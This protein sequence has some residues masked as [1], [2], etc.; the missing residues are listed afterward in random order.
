MFGFVQ[1][2][3]SLYVRPDEPVADDALVDLAA[4]VADRSSIDWAEV[5]ASTDDPQTRSAI[6]RLKLIDWIAGACT[7]DAEAPGN[8]SAIWPSPPFAWGPLHVVEQVGRGT[9]GDVYRA[10]DQRL[11]REVALKLLRREG[12][13]SGAVATE[14]TGAISRRFAP[15]RGA[16][17]LSR[18]ARCFS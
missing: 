3:V 4:A 7:P 10:I 14:V 2:G 16:P 11:D 15:A 8:E 18:T 13:A 1:S 6:E 5:A 9:F 12:P 17:R